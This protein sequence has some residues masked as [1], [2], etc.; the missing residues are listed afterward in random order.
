MYTMFTLKYLTGTLVERA[1]SGRTYGWKTATS[2]AKREN[3]GKDVR[4]GDGGEKEVIYPSVI[5]SAHAGMA[6][7]G[8]LLPSPSNWIPRLFNLAS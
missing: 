4:G 2:H 3:A 5:G 8:Y 1:P 6:S 7:K